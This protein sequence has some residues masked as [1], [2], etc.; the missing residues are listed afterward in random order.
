[1]VATPPSHRVTWKNTSERRTTSVPPPRMY[2]AWHPRGEQATFPIERSRELRHKGTIRLKV[3]TVVA[4]MRAAALA[5]LLLPE[6]P[7]G[8]VRGGASARRSA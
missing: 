5:D 7:T 2:P 1:M 3:T 4:P 6:L 8:A